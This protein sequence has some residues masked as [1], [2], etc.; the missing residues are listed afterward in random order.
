MPAGLWFVSREWG[1]STEPSYPVSFVVVDL[2]VGILAALLG[3]A[4]VAGHR[5]VHPGVLLAL[6]LTCTVLAYAP[7]W[8]N[9]DLA[10]ILFWAGLAFPIVAKLG[11][12]AADLNRPHPGRRAKVMA[13]VGVAAIAAGAV[14]PG[15][16]L[17]WVS[18]DV[19]SE[20]DIA[21]DFILVPLVAVGF[22]VHLGRR[23]P[24]RRP[25]AEPSPT[26]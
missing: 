25:D 21:R 18:P 19:F 1:V 15:I 5:I 2:W 7:L 11:F 23:V 13:A 4:W 22:A 12:D 24:T 20:A 9:S 8:T 3:V 16:A 14:I 26:P 17:G 6:V 10:A